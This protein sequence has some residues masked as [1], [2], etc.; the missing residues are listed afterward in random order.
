M[1]TVYIAY[2][3]SPIHKRPMAICLSDHNHARRQVTALI[4]LACRE[5]FIPETFVPYTASAHI[6]VSR[7]AGSGWRWKEHLAQAQAHEP[8]LSAGIITLP[9]SLASLHLT[10]HAQPFRVAQ[11]RSV[12]SKDLVDLILDENKS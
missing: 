7:R 10:I 1:P 6:T 4:Q 11:W 5:L 9:P 3:C 8:R 2:I 12:R